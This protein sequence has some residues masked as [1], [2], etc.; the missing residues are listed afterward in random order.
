MRAIEG[1]GRS[2]GIAGMRP[3]QLLAIAA[4]VAAVLFGIAGVI[5]AVGYLV[6]VSRYR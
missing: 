1:N 6:S 2:A 3:G 4:V 5:G